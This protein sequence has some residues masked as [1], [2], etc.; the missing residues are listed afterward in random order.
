MEPQAIRNVTAVGQPGEWVPGLGRIVIQGREIPYTIYA[1]K[2]GK[3]KTYKRGEGI[4]R[5][6]RADPRSEADR[7]SGARTWG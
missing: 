6:W 3:A 2:T 5:P 4:C 7:S 1:F